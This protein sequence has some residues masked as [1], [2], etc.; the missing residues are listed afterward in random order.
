MLGFGWCHLM[1][2][3]EQLRDAAL[4]DVKPIDESI[5]RADTAMF[6]KFRSWMSEQDDPF[7]VWN[8]LEKHNNHC[9]L[10]TYSLSRNHRS[11]V[12]WSMLDWIVENAD[13]SYGLFYCYDDEDTMDRNAYGRETPM[14]YDNSIEFI[15]SKMGSLKSSLTHSLA[16][17][18]VTSGQ[19]T[20]MTE[21]YSNKSE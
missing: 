6:E 17:L 4:E 11:S 16:L 10:L 20:P 5:D 12:V 14:N 7:F 1:T 18:M 3:R 2:S 21:V 9:G 13:G 8:L 19:C 15:A